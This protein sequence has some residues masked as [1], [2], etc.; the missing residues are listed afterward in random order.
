MGQAA[1]KALMSGA[2]FLDWEQAQTERHEFVEGQI[3]AM[4]GAEARHVVIAMNAAR[5][6]DST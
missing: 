6:Y 4:A 5:R 3:V 2:E 1:A